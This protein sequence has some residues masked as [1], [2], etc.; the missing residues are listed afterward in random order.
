V[1]DP[2]ARTLLQVAVQSCTLL[3]ACVFCMTAAVRLVPPTGDLQVWEEQRCG[4]FSPEA[5][6]RHK[7][8]GSGARDHQ[9]RLCPLRAGRWGQGAAHSSTQQLSDRAARDS[10][11]KTAAGKAGS[12]AS[13]M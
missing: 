4:C 5:D 9:G 10:T 7:P 2:I 13:V 8:S 6:W 11:S 3:G 12:H 1:L